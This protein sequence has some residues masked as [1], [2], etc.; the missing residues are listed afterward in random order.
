MLAG[1]GVESDRLATTRLLLQLAVVKYFA[2]RTIRW[3]TCLQR[4]TPSK[5]LFVKR[6][7]S[8]CIAN[9]LLESSYRSASR[10][11]LSLPLTMQPLISLTFFSIP[12]PF[13]IQLEFHHPLHSI[14][15]L[16]WI[17]NKLCPLQTHMVRIHVQSSLY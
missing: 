3:V 7:L 10:R 11:A 5:G 1:V 8:S 9:E 4:L 13:P 12:L 14:L 6:S 15:V 16:P 17:I 2:R